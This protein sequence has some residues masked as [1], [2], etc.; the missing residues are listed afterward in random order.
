MTPG[1]FPLHL[2]RGD[3]Y[4]WRFNLWTDTAGTVAADVS[5]VTAKAE[6]RDKPGG[7]AITQLTC[8]V[9]SGEGSSAVLVELTAEACHSLPAAGAWDLQ[10]TYTSGDVATVLAGVVTVTADVTDSTGSVA[11]GIAPAAATVTAFP[12]IRRAS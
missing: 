2:Y 10:L 4:R 9:E 1:S 7:S 11:P 12:R 8:T 6:I 5:G 3:T